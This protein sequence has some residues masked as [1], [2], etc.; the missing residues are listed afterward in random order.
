MKI[1]ILT[2]VLSLILIGLSQLAAQ[3]PARP[4][5]KTPILRR[6]PDFASWTVQLSYPDE[7]EK[8]AAPATPP[9]GRSDRIRSVTVSKTGKTY[10]EL[11]T[12]TSGRREEKWTFGGVQLTTVNNGRSIVLIE[13]P[14]SEEP[15]PEYSD[16]TRSD[17]PELQ[18]VSVENY[19]GVQNHQGKPAYRFESARERETMTAFL[20]TET[21]LPFSFSMR[22]AE[23]SYVFNPP[24]TAPL[25]PPERFL[26]VLR[27]HQ[28]GLQALKFHP[29][30]P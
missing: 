10:R 25:A 30:S 23:R 28:K 15:S 5:P 19:T 12:W 18:W 11:T 9:D 3:T 7:K 2:A 8:A 27:T 29:R 16:F 21:Q 14:T 20:S 24:P 6:A 22:D 13:A 17:F 4:A 26:R 1:R